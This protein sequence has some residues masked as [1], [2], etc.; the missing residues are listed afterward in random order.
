MRGYQ[1]QRERTL[2]VGLPNGQGPAVI[3]VQL[4]DMEAGKQR[5]E[6]WIGNFGGSNVWIFSGDV[7]L[8]EA[9][10]IVARGAGELIDCV[11]ALSGSVATST[12]LDENTHRLT[13][14]F[15]GKNEA[16]QTQSVSLKIEEYF[17]EP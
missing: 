8:K 3:P 10:N 5:V 9:E 1:L 14:F 7:S 15:E 11:M 16:G 17:R 6:A 12:D 13:V 4:R 2:T